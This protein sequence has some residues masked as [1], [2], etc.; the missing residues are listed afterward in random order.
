MLL[1]PISCHVACP[2]H[3]MALSWA[4]SSGHCSG[5]AGLAT[6]LSVVQGC[7]G[8]LHACTTCTLAEACDELTLCCGVFALQVVFVLNADDSG[9]IQTPV[10]GMPGGPEL[11]RSIDWV[12]VDG[13]TVRL[14]C[15]STAAV[16]ANPALLIIDEIMMAPRLSDAVYIPWAS[17]GYWAGRE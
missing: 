17:C 10:P 6:E 4:A 13:M 1:Q 3:P 5:R 15:A 14:C 8:H 11:G 12:L 16:C 2:C 9:Q 7:L